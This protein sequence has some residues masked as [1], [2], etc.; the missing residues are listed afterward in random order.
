MAQPTS[1]HQQA[2]SRILRYIKG[3]PVVDIFFSIDSSIQLKGFSDLDWA[4][5]IDTRRSITG[6]VVYL[7]SF[8]I[9]W[10]S[11]KWA[12]VSRSF[13]EAEYKALV[14]ATCELQWLTF[15]LEE[16]KVVFHQLVVLYCDNKPALL[17]TA[18]PVFHERTKHIK[19]DCQ[20]FERRSLQGLLSCYQ[21]LLPISLQIYTPKHS[22]LVLFS[23][24]TPS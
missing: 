21:Y 23:S 20:S 1:P 4:G 24:Y 7:G 11:K 17:I 16:F 3:S 12:T 5:C 13:L 18:N 8:L 14:S 2:A 6:F 9:S 15:L 19:I 10:K 22:C